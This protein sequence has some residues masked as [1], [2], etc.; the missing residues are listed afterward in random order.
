MGRFTDDDIRIILLNIVSL[1]HLFLLLF[2][3]R[4]AL[5]TMDVIN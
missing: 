2:H 4:N 5:R 3:S 1:N